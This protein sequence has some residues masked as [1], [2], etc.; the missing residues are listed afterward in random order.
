MY[1]CKSGSAKVLTSFEKIKEE[2][3]ENGPLMVSCSI[4]SDFFGYSSGFYE[5]T[6]DSFEGL[7][8]MK[9]VGWGNDS[10][11]GEYFIIQNQWGSVWGDS[12]FIKVKKGEIGIDI[13]AV[14]CEPD[15]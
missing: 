4:Y 13:F 10:T 6:T 9:V 7:H 5:K 1:R 15:V 12:G 14:A 8:A 3:Y 11:H 2:V